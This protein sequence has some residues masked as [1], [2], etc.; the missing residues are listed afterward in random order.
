MGTLITMI[1]SFITEQTGTVGITL[2]LNTLT[3]EDSIETITTIVTLF[4][5]IVP[6][7][8]IIDIKKLNIVK[9]LK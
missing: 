7:F 2:T 1:G 4:T 5:I 8:I 9:K 3:I 6:L